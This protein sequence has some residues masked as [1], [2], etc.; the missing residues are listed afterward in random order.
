MRDFPV[1]EAGERLH[2]L[3]HR[4][5]RRSAFVNVPSFSRNDE[6]GR[7]TCANFAVSF[8]NRSCTTMHSID[9][10]A[11]VTC[12]VFG[13]GLRDVFALD[14]HALEAAV[15]RGVEHVRDAQAR[16]GLQRHAPRSL[17]QR[18]HGRV[19]DVTVARQLVRERA[20]V[21]RALHVVLA[22][23]RVHADAFAAD[24]AGGHR[25]VRDADDGGRALAVLGDAEA[26]VDRRVRRRSRTA[27]RRRAP[28]AGHAGLASAGLGRVLADRGRTRATPRTPR[29]RSARR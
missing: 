18:A 22:A 26:V 5:M 8:R 16:L 29:P 17:E 10:S 20:H 15:E 13:I 25:E 23:Q 19:R 3:A 4:E 27:A 28:A 1:R 24:V 7:N 11:A 14:V 6:P 9:D 2:D 12:C 21:A